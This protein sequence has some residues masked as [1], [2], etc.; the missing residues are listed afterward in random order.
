MTAAVETPRVVIV[1]AGIAA[2][3]AALALA[4]RPVLVLSPAPLGEGCSS[5]WAQGGIA[6]AMAADDSPEAHAADTVRAGAGTVDP[7]VA[8]RITAS[9]RARIEDLGRLGIPFDR[10]GSGA[11][12]LGL[13]AAHST[14]RIVKVKGDQSGREVM[15]GL[16]AA[17]RAAPSVQVVEGVRVLRLHKVG[18]RVAGVWV[19]RAEDAPVQP[20]LI[21]CPAVLLAGGGAAGLFAVTTNPPAIRGEALGMAARAGAVVADA[22]FVQFHPTA[23]DIGGEYAPL[24]TEALRGAGATLIDRAGRRFMRDAHPDAELAPRDVV[25]RAVFA[26]VQAGNRPLLDTRSA[27]GARI[28]DDFPAVYAGCHRAGVDPVTQPIPVAPAAHYHMGG[29]ATDLRGRCSL[30]GLWVCGEAAAT[31]LHGAN[32]LASNGL[33]EALAMGRAAAADLAAELGACM[34]A[35]APQIALHWQA[36]GPPAPDPETVQA[37][38]RVMTDHVGVLREAGGFAMR[39]RRLPALRRSIPIATGC[40]TWRRPQP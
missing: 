38:R 25:A 40:R 14:A 26:Q 36:G 22:E 19:N 12:L 18:G 10:D 7:E 15:A 24:A 13:E 29:V 37:L 21:A 9:A 8:H 31:G 23:L 20:V 39:W 11:Y 5:A 30:P 2:L 35:D 33:L 16:V 32:R 3:S 6:A 4:P 17:V 34:A 1:G 28:R 27:L